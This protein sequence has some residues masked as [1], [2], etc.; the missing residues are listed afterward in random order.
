MVQSMPSRCVGFEYIRCLT[1]FCVDLG[2]ENNAK[3]TECQTCPE[4]QYSSPG[5][6]CQ[7]CGRGSTN[8]DDHTQ[9]LCAIDFFDIT[10]GGICKPCQAGAICN[11]VGTKLSS[12]MCQGTDGGSCPVLKVRQGYWQI[13]PE[14][15]NSEE[16]Q[17]QEKTQLTFMSCSKIGKEDLCQGS[18]YPIPRGFG[19]ESGCKICDEDAMTR[20]GINPD[21][22]GECPTKEVD[23]GLGCRKGHMG[24]KCSVCIR[25]V[26]LSCML[27]MADDGLFLVSGYVKG[28]DGLCTPC[29]ASSESEK[30]DEEENAKIRNSFLAFLALLIGIA[31]C[32]SDHRISTHICS[33]RAQSSQLSSSYLRRQRGQSSKQCTENTQITGKCAKPR[34]ILS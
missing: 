24:I 18:V 26:T 34:Q 32:M 3:N 22:H 11:K 4:G 1:L 7:K 15:S 10:G 16:L 31:T 5:S 14:Y 13:H 25:W 29:E 23:C 9:C 28:T 19:S 20:D 21:E 12:K 30:L 8:S 33:A 2:Q 17:K 27:V 6:G